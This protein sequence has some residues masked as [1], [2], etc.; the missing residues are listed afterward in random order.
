MAA[1]GRN[2]ILPRARSFHSLKTPRK[3]CPIQLEL[4]GLCAFARDNLSYCLTSRYER[5]EN[6]IEHKKQGVEG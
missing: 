3:K 2:Q 6:K 1:E 5:D 4:C